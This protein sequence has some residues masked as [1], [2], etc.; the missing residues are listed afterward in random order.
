MLKSVFS[1]PVGLSVAAVVAGL[2][3]LPS[4]GAS[5]ADTDPSV[6]HAAKVNHLSEAQVRAKLSADHS[7]HIARSGRFYAIDPAPA[8]VSGPRL[9]PQPAAP[10]N[11]TFLLHSNPTSTHTIY[12]DF[13]GATVSGS[14]WNEANPDDP[15]STPLP[16]D[17]YEGWN[18]D[19]TAGFGNAERTAIQ[20]VWRRVSEDYAPFDVD[21]TT[22]DPG[23][24]DL[25]RTDATD[26]L[27]GDRV[28]FTDSVTA[29]TILCDQNCGGLAFIGTFG[30]Q[31]DAQDA[32]EPAWIFPAG[33][34][35]DV[36]SF[37]ADAASHEVGHNFGL[38]HDGLGAEDYFAPDALWGPIMG[39]PYGSGVTQWSQGSYAGA[40]N[41]QD[42]VA[43]I[44]GVAGLR[45][46]EAPSTITAAPTLGTGHGYISAR[47]DK[48]TY[49]LGDCTGTVTFTAAPAETGADLDIKLELLNAAGTVVTSNDPAATHDGSGTSTASGLGASI[50]A[51]LTAGVDYVRVDGVGTG[52]WSTTNKY[53]DY[54]SLGEYQL[55]RTGGSCSTVVGTLPGAPK[56]VVATP[57]AALPQVTVTWDAP[58]SAGSSSIT[59]Y[60]VAVQGGTSTTVA[61]DA[62]QYTF[63]GLAGS[64][65]YTFTVAAVSAVGTGTSS[66]AQATTAASSE[67]APST[68]QNL[69]AVPDAA[70]PEV[71]LEWAAPAAAGTSPV[72]EYEISVDGTVIGSTPD[73]SA[74]ID[75]LDPATTYQFGV[76]AVSAAGKSPAATVSATTAAPPSAPQAFTA[77]ADPKL[78]QVKLSWQ[79]PADHGSSAITGYDIYLDG[80]YVGSTVASVRGG[81][82][83]GLD[84][85]TTY[86]FDVT[87]VND[88]G[89][90][91]S[92]SATA[93]TAAAPKPVVKHA[94]TTSI[95]VPSKVKKGKRPTVKVTVAPVGTSSAPT[96]SVKLT[97]GKKTVTLALKGGVATYKAPK[98][99]KAGKVKVS[100]SYLGSGAFTAS[101]AKPKTFR[102]K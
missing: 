2:L 51:D 32:S 58:D 38:D 83:N 77:T 61:A 25:A 6:T 37:M 24:A 44:G 40:T 94:T 81:I 39:A 5:A 62:R 47:S 69:T 36:A 15:T 59:G 68:P 41:H 8:A 88:T 11:Q 89:A 19:G 31:P 60:Q 99:K 20:E 35:P 16:D 54:G 64:T 66:S 50:T 76:V 17:F 22:E 27:F 56:N 13:D 97:V 84:Y 12:L 65:L 96:G 42:D 63:T 49:S 10:L 48:D 71:A 18:P 100:A 4:S 90:S 93:T 30:Q 23:A 85:A 95:S 87:A 70:L 86:D 14:W 45:T 92:A 46:D 72:T 34:G 82:V 73:L 29:H 52:T 102:V 57:D 26:Q 55:T 53:D 78:P 21:V 3:A 33:L 43:I 101:S 28:L 74:L 7:L 1:R 91:E 79:A 75:G 98:Q 9:A 80:D 67:Q